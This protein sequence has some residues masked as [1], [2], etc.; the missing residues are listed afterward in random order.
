[1]K[2]VSEGFRHRFKT[3]ENATDTFKAAQLS[4][5]VKVRLSN[6]EI[7]ALNDAAQ[8]KYKKEAAKVGAMTTYL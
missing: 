2:G 1:V 3:R 4:G 5:D 6:R 8:E 7:R